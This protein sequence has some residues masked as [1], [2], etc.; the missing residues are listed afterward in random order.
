MD[1]THTFEIKTNGTT[2]DG[3]AEFNTDG[4]ASY[5]TEEPMEVTVPQSERITAIFNEV[6]RLFESFGGLEKLEIN[7]I[8]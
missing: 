6:Q 3:E 4:I 5:K 1:Y 8:E 7:R 2:I